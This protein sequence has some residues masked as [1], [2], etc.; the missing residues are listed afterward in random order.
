M[1]KSHNWPAKD[2]GLSDGNFKHEDSPLAYLPYPESR[3]GE[4]KKTYKAA[5]GHRKSGNG[6]DQ[7]DDENKLL[8]HHGYY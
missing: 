2:L 3:L 7:R 4:F 8:Y 6:Q 1:E 5:G